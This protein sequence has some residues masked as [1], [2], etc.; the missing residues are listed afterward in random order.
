MIYIV[1]IRLY[2]TVRFNRGVAQPGA[3]MVTLITMIPLVAIVAE[4]FYRLVEMPSKIFAHK[5]FEWITK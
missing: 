3:A 1:G 2:K 5:A 4:I